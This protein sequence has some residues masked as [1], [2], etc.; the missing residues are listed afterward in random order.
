MVK[1][2]V[3]SVGTSSL[4]KYIIP[5]KG[6]TW[7]FPVDAKNFDFTRKGEYRLR[8]PVEV[9]NR[10]GFTKKK[11]SLKVQNLEGH[12]VYTA[13]TEK[14]GCAKRYSVDNWQKFMADNNLI[15]GVMLDFTFVTS[16]NTI[17]LRKVRS[18]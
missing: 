2:N 18:G 16:K 5:K 17:I 14:I 11:H 8:L 3:P 10:A 9:A 7:N 4:K 6:Q 13:K 15:N 12:V 1:Q